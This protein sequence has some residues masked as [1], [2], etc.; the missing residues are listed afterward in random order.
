M[1]IDILQQQKVSLGALHLNVRHIL[2]R[3]A[4]VLTAS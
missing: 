3:E 4:V 2:P 1:S